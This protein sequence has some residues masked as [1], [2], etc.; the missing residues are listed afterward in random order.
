VAMLEA[1]VIA[2]AMAFGASV[3]LALAPRLGL[4]ILRA[5]LFVY[6]LGLGF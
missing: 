3:C 6:A 4:T 5:L 1:T 2:Y